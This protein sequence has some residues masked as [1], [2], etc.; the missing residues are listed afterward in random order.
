MMAVM[1][2]TKLKDFG[3]SDLDTELEDP[4]DSRFRAKRYSGTDLN[5]IKSNVLPAFSKLGAYP[6]P[7]KLAEL[8][9]KYWN[10]NRNARRADGPAMPSMPSTMT[11]EERQ[12]LH[13]SHH[14][15]GVPMPPS[16][17]TG[18]MSSHHSASSG[19]MMQ[20]VRRDGPR[21]TMSDE[22]RQKLHESH[23][24]KGSPMPPA[25]ATGDMS[26]HHSSGNGKSMQRRDGPANPSLMT[27][28]E[29]LRQH[30]A[31]HGKGVPMPPSMTS[32]DM[33][34]H[35]SGGRGMSTAGRRKS[36]DI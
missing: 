34:S 33:S 12:K 3:Y 27:D 36:I 11:D 24:G 25:M 15:K 6:D 10:S 26:S 20:R 21:P 35:H 2:V 5:D 16:M 19:K 18:D 23:H 1:N 4:M 29:R 30:E 14:G 9:S 32:G 13:E 31:H 28:E 22:E 17:A 8:E 7:V